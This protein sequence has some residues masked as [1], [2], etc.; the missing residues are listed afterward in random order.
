MYAC[1]LQCF[2][3]IEQCRWPV[4]AAVHGACIGGGVDLITAC[5]IRLCSQEATFCVKEVDLAITVGAVS[6]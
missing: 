6:Q 5:D 4:V 3:S 2:T 1:L